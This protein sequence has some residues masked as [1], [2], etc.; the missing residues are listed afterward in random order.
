MHFMCPNPFNILSIKVM[1]RR[2]VFTSNIAT[3]PQKSFCFK[4]LMM[5]G[6]FN[7]HIDF[8]FCSQSR[9]RCTTDVT[10]RNK[11]ISESTR[12]STSL[13]LEHPRPSR[14]ERGYLAGKNQCLLLSK[15]SA[16]S[17]ITT[18]LIKEKAAP[19]R[20]RCLQNILCLSQLRDSIAEGK[21]RVIVRATTAARA[22]LIRS[23]GIN[24][25][26][27]TMM[28]CSMVIPAL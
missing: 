22:T 25:K 28:A 16:S 19:G 20:N 7:E 23:P 17:I 27:P 6:Y 11:I 15:G 14:I 8:R 2:K 5:A 13:L 3:R 26:L 24:G 10:D 4:R 1:F 12:D 18:Q 21:P 9:N